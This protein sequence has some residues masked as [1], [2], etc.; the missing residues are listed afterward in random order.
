[1]L[2]VRS[3]R[4]KTKSMFEN[5]SLKVQ[6]MKNLRHLKKT[7]EF[8]QSSSTRKNCRISKLYFESQTDH[9]TVVKCYKLCLRA[10]NQFFVNQLSQKIKVS[11]LAFDALQQS[12]Y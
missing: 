12:A 5:K 11:I 10:I 1:M 2:G 7:V 6:V 3:Q 4:S 9:R 8:Q